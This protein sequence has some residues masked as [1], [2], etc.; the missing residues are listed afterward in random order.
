MTTIARLVALPDTPEQVTV[1]VRQATPTGGWEV[2]IEGGLLSSG[3]QSES[4]DDLGDALEIAAQEVQ[5]A[6]SES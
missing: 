6:I 2:F 1:I 5:L 4:W 3:K